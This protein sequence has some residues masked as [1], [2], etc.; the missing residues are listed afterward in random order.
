MTESTRKAIIIGAGPAGLATALRL[1]QKTNIQCTVYELRPEPTT[2]GGAIG[3]QP[4]GLRLLDRLGVYDAMCG[5]G[6][7][8]ANLTLHSLQGHVIGT[9]DYV[10]WAREKIGYGYMRIK[11]VDIVDVMKAKVDDAGIPIIYGKRITE[12]QEENDG[13]R[14]RFEDGTVDTADILFGCDGIHSFVR[15][16]FVDPGYL[17]EY[18][19]VSGLGALVPGQVLSKGHL[20]MMTGLEGTL[21]EEGMLAVNPCAPNKEEVFMFFSKWLPIPETGDSRDGWE[22]HRKE[23]VDGFK[24]QLM[25]VLKDARGE[26]GDALREVVQSTSSVNFYPVYRLP[27]GGRWS[28][29]RCVLVGD[30]AHAMSP[31]AG[32]GV[33]MAM[34]DVFLL[35]RLLEDP[36]RPI[37]EVFQKYDQICRPRVD[38]IFTMAAQNAQMRKQRTSTGLWWQELKLSV[39]LNVSWAFGLDKRGLNQGHLVYDIEEVE[40]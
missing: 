14:V 17:P 37:D 23:E 10:G 19:G 32:Q 13:V 20:E 35:A 33:S 8:G 6:Y 30:A 3:I 25:G 28:R 36:E 15:S 39:M 16:H 2:L 9:S 40:L 29:G 12:I 18:S 24:D 22:V 4:N 31:H 34:E 27:L 26:W 21:T 5:R 7:G 11:R 1:Q 38:S